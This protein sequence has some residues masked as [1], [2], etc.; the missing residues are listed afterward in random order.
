MERAKKNWPK[1]GMVAVVQGHPFI[2]R[3]EK[4]VFILTGDQENLCI[5]IAENRYNTQIWREK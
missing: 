4:I 5:K 2:K 1:S 3:V